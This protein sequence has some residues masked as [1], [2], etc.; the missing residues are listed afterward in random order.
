MKEK[1]LIIIKTDWRILKELKKE[2]GRKLMGWRML[3]RAHSSEMM[4]S[5]M[6]VVIKQNNR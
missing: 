3:R 5:L 1:K 2:K 4:K 6:I